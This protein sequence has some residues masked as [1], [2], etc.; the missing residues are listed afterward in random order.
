MKTL[1]F[2]FKPDGFIL[3]HVSTEE[4]N[5]WIQKFQA[6]KY[7]ALYEWG[8]QPKP[9]KAT[10]SAIF[11]HRVAELYVDTLTKNNELEVARDQTKIRVT[12]D[13]WQQLEKELPFSLGSE[14]INF[15]WTNHIFEELHRIFQQEI[16]EYPNSVKLY[17][18]EK[19][20]NLRIPERIFFHLVENKDDEYPF[21]FLATYATKDKDGIVRHM[22]LRY[23]LEEYKGDRDRLVKLLSCLNQ[24]AK[25]CELLSSLIERGELFHPL[26][27][28]SKEA[29]ELLKHVEEIEACG[30]LCRIPNWWRKKYANVSLTMKIGDKKPSLLGF[31]SLL[32]V[33]PEFSVDGVVLSGQEVK[34]LLMQSEGL[35][36]L[37]GKWIEV[38]HEKLRRLLQNMEQQKQKEI[39][40]FEALRSTLKEDPDNGVTIS[41]GQWFQQFLQDLRAP[42]KQIKT[43]YPK[44]LNATLRPYQEIGFAWLSQ[45]NRCGFGACL[46]D[47]MGLGKTI[48][49][50]SFLESFR[51]KHKQARA[52]LIVPASLLGNWEKEAKQFTPKLSL[53]LMHGK[54]VSQLEKEFHENDAF[55]T[56]TT[57]GMAIKL[58]A[59]KEKTWDCLILDEAQAIKNPITKQTKA[60]KSL[61]A[62]MRI[63]MTGTPIENDLSNLWSL[64]DFLNK[65]LLG[66]YQEFKA[67]AKRLDDN[68]QGYQ[69]L[70]MMISPFILRRLKTD[71]TIIQDLPEK[72]EVED[73]V[74]LSKQQTAL[75]RN[76]IDNLE[77]KLNELDGIERK[78]LILA[79]LSKLKQICNHPDQ[80]LGE[81]A[82]LAKHSGKFETLKNICETIYEKR[83]RVLIFTQ[84]KEIIPYL[85]KFLSEIFH[86]EGFV[87]H[88]STPVKKR[89]ELVEKFQHENYVPYIVLS[90]K[91]AGTGLN[92]T[93]ANHV[94]HFDR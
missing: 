92:L 21:A 87:L 58:K 78:G 5:E 90:L 94:I 59:L 48:Q 50:L 74:T 7:E 81:Q 63:I 29:Y 34:K 54:P 72:I 79:A 12:E 80:Y 83:E 2:I 91:A 25:T 27:F 14:Y 18:A 35:A 11:L 23:A 26:R 28:T 37:K 31:D 39:T 85:S 45:M 33:K 22:P 4:T 1:N 76:Y 17:L 66:S 60:I 51:L 56:I 65:G 40:M 30:I 73:Y 19:N 52:L 49:V 13:I 24:A 75:Y 77:M 43:T 57:Y 15:D 55:L 68:P 44:S 8:F 64:F 89:M 67:F 61:H 9:D 47:D 16:K 86:Q 20:Q 36:F 84:Y 42:K 71:K 62:N 6:N 32:S 38:N 88:G 93:E 82:Y 69:K 46:A 53:Y 70:K 10:P 41:N 3:D